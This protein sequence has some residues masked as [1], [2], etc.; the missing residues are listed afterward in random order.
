MTEIEYRL[1]G[2]PA[3]FRSFPNRRQADTFVRS[4]EA[5][6]PNVEVTYWT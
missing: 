5:R 6:F 4:L 2:K 1:P 3:N